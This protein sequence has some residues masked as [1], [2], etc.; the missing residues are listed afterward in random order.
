M[1]DLLQR[2][3]KLR[4]E[5]GLTQG[6]GRRA[7]CASG[8]AT[9]RRFRICI[10]VSTAA[11]DPARS[12]GGSSSNWADSMNSSGRSTW[13]TPISASAPGSAAGRSSISPIAAFGTSTAARSARR[14]RARSSN[15]PSRRTSCCLPGRTFTSLDAWPHT[16]FTP[17]L[18]RW[19]ACSSAIHRAPQPGRPFPRFSSVAG[20]MRARWRARSLAVI[21]DRE[22]FGVPRRVL[23]RPLCRSAHE[24]LPPQ[25][26]LS[27]ALPGVPAHSRRR[28][29]MYQT[30]RRLGPLAD[31]HL[32]ALLTPPGRSKLI[33]NW[34]RFSPRWSF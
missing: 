20:A 23:S 31:V 11:A 15:A 19:S 34:P 10:R 12:T 2:P 22:A 7:P 25:R 5:T 8:T 27:I 6:G 3:N 4:E 29:F 24:S 1:P 17:S 14:S 33:R 13:K 21:D 32:I 18:T 30:L 9:T 26:P 16:S 28:V